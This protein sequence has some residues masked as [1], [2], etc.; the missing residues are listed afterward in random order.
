M[1]WHM[2]PET[3]SEWQTE[4][5]CCTQTPAAWSPT[6]ACRRWQ[7]KGPRPSTG[8]GTPLCWLVRPEVCQTVRT[9]EVI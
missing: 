1:G 6:D 3:E 8:L 5:A 2:E 9:F 4:A 7:C